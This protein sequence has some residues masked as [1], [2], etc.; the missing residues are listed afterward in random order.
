M[1]VR[2]TNE[3]ATPRTQTPPAGSALA[4]DSQEHRVIYRL[5]GT[6][7]VVELLRPAAGNALD[8]PLRHGLSAA[9]RRVRADGDLVRAVPLTARGRHFYVGQDLKE[10]A[11]ALEKSPASAFAIVLPTV[12]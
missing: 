5:E 3:P 4:A 2:A 10:H 11:R 9:V 12:A 1:A 6:V 8:I 7:A